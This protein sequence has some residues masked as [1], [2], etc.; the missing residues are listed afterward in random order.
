MSP[1]VAGVTV[2]RPSA[3]DDSVAPDDGSAAPRRRVAANATTPIAPNSSIIGAAAAGRAVAGRAARALRR[4][5]RVVNSS[6][7]APAM[8]L[9]AVKFVAFTPGRTVSIL[10]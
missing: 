10:V 4:W 3:D 1:F 7:G 6:S 9:R 5:T 8:L 2:C